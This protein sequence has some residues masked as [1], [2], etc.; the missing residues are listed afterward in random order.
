MKSNRYKN[1]NELLSEIEALGDWRDVSQRDNFFKIL[2]KITVIYNG[3]KVTDEKGKES[4]KWYPEEVMEAIVEA[5]KGKFPNKDEA[6]EKIDGKR[7]LKPGCPDYSKYLVLVNDALSISLMG[8]RTRIDEIARNEFGI[9]VYN[10]PS[11]P[12][13]VEEL[14]SSSK[15]YLEKVKE[16]TPSIDKNSATEINF[17]GTTLKECVNALLKYQSRGESVVVNFNGHKLYSADVTMD[18]AFQEVTGKTKAEFDKAQEEW[19]KEYRERQ[20]REEAKAQEQIPYWLE[21]GSDLIYPERAEE[22]K[23]CV[24]ARAKDLYHGMDL[25]AAIE[26]MEMLENGSLDDAKEVLEGQDHSGASYGMVRNIVFSFS[27]KGPEFWE[28]TAKDKISAETRK[29]IEEKKKQNAELAELHKSDSVEKVSPERRAEEQEIT[30][31]SSEK[32]QLT[33]EISDI[34]QQLETSKAQETALK[35]SLAEKQSKLNG[36]EE[37]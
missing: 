6:F 33:A 36:L 21:K 11:T 19:R 20:A 30:T 31:L 18:G 7:R 28:H 29:V 14:I 26:I 12:E 1:I 2:S 23:Q 22:W 24:E 17:Y 34:K 8:E 13:D 32:E 25:N 5:C 9:D 27:K 15:E 4:S 35:K 3:Y 37:K 16:K 10:T